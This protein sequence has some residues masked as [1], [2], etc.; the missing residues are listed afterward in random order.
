M[1]AHESGTSPATAK[2]RQA[3]SVPAV[4]AAAAPA[5]YEADRVPPGSLAA[6]QRSIGNAALARLLEEAAR[7]HGAHGHE[8]HGHE[9]H[10]HDA[11]GRDAGCDRTRAG[12]G[13]APVQRSAV[14]EVLGGAGRPLAAPLRSEMEARLEADFS[15][16][17][18]HTGAAAARSATEVGA[19]A[20][21]SG[22]HIVI[23]TGGADKHTLAHELTH[24][25]QQR[26]GPVAGTDDGGGL[27]ISDPSDRFEREAE[28]NATRVMRAPSPSGDG[29]RAAE[30]VHG[31]ATTTA[32]TPGETTVQRKS[33]IT[34][35]NPK[36]QNA[37]PPH[38]SLSAVFA[39]FFATA[40]LPEN[41]T[42]GPLLNVSPQDYPGSFHRAGTVRAEI[43]P[44]SVS[45]ADGSNRDNSVIGPYGH[46][47]VMER[48]IFNR[49]PLGN[50]YDGG[51][52]V[53]HTLMEGQDADVH[54]NIA[55]QENKNFNQGLMRGW[56]AVPE[57]LMHSGHA[58]Y[59]NVAVTYSSDTY[60]RTG[61]DLVNAGVIAPGAVA[62][63]NT[64]ASPLDPALTLAQELV[65]QTVEFRRWVPVKWEGQ[66]VE[67]NQ[68]DF[69]NLM[70]TYGAHYRNLLPSQAA[71][72][73]A[74]MDMASLAQ[75]TY[76]L[77]APGTNTLVRQHSGTLAGFIDTAAVTTAGLLTVGGAPSISAAMYQPEPQDVRDQPHATTTPAGTVPVPLPPA[78]IVTNLLSTPVSL[79]AMHTELLAVATKK[80]D[81]LGG[82]SHLNK[83]AATVDG[84]A[85]KQSPGFK[86]IRRFLVNAEEGMKLVV[87]I[88]GHPA[89]S[90][91]G[92]VQ[93]DA[94]IKRSGITVDSQNKL[95]AL[96]Y[97]PNL[98]S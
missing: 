47:G 14:H 65:R 90:A 86:E 89:T 8:T 48:A 52:L 96:A 18:V 83:N 91:F 64:I 35:N 27:R 32:H 42:F 2:P 79:S 54:G 44:Q 38:R 59:Y 84:D 39:P 66:V 78:N 46:F 31:T 6:L 94:A 15:D 71:A 87:A 10:G 20:Y 57:K 16:V 63:M 25:I 73:Q 3:M 23:G 55:P 30:D 88:Q 62:V 72:E 19:R 82:L 75:H 41:Y 80:K 69:P 93:F 97:D 74:V 50:T 60:T 98:T 43:D 76:P 49:P 56:E 4:S 95:Q 61:E 70:L 34:A 85:K 36:E 29:G 22:N 81:R 33:A 68:A 5:A 9:T 13:P 11:H 77:A 21:T 12:D 45:K 28:A 26:T 17:R 51:H 7:E 92:R 58:F 37:A 24:V 67:P 40:Q 1:R 53:E